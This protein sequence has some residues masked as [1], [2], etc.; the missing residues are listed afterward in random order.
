[1]NLSEELQIVATGDGSFTLYQPFLNAHYHSV[2]GAV[3]ESRHVFL[4]GGQ[5]SKRLS[6]SPEVRVLEVGLG[7]GLNLWLTLQTCRQFPDSFL[8]YTAFEPFPVPPALLRDYYQRMGIDSNW[9]DQLSNRQGVM[10]RGN[11]QAEFKWESWPPAAFAEEFDIIYYDAFAPKFAPEMWKADTFG[12]AL[13]ALAPGGSLVTYSVTG[14]ARRLAERM[15]KR[16]EKLVGF[17]P[18]REM[19]RVW[20]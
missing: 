17:G 13:T 9:A 12:R 16:V 6:E 11:W 20:G 15:G 5:L 7:S 18:K 4:E 3:G 8:H 19:L 10:A 1:L 2:A 14:E